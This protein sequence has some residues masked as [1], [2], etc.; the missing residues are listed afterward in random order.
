M[1]K[2][3]E[4]VA[5]IINDGE[6][7]FCAQ[8]KDQ[9]ELAKKWEFPGGKIEPHETKE[10]TIVRE[11]KEELKTDIEVMDYLMTVQHEYNT[12]NLIMHAYRCKVIKGNLELTEH[13][14]SAWLTVDEMKNYDFAAAD[15]PII[16]ML[17]GM[18]K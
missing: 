4:V 2:T 14:D 11:I 13:L 8:R 10:E 5:A 12:F 6:R 7:I 15:I 9:G 16:E 18:N 1:K 3:I 17:A